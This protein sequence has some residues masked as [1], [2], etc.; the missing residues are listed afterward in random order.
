MGGGG[1]QFQ[2]ILALEENLLLHNISY[3]E[4]ID[5]YLSNPQPYPAFNGLDI[6]RRTRNFKSKNPE[7]TFNTKFDCPHLVLSFKSL[8]NL[9][10]ASTT[11][12][13]YLELTMIY[14]NNSLPNLGYI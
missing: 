13:L 1:L 3:F 11:F 9:V 12:V 8:Q 14:P 6:A 10:Y 7:Y 5:F 2:S 4:K